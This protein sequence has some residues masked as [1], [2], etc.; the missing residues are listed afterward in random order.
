MGEKITL[1]NFKAEE[2]VPKKRQ[3]SILSKYQS[4]PR[5]I[6]KSIITLIKKIDQKTGEDTKYKSNYFF[7]TPDG[8]ITVNVMI[9]SSGGEKIGLM[10]PFMKDLGNIS[11]AQAIFH[12]LQMQTGLDLAKLD[13]A[14]L[15]YPMGLIGPHGKIGQ[16]LENYSDNLIIVNLSDEKSQKILD[17]ATNP[18]TVEEWLETD[19]FI[20]ILN[21]CFPGQSIEFLKKYLLNMPDHP[22]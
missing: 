18:F 6:I 11:K 4:Y 8:P 2:N 14:I 1:P 5:I 20:Y 12:L 17:L 9:E 3:V 21:Q 16:I 19:F 10:I 22:F 13:K 7:N 15:I